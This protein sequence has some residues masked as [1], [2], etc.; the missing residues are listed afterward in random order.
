MENNLSVEYIRWFYKPLK[1]KNITPTVEPFSGYDTVRI[2]TKYQE[3]CNGLNL[4]DCKLEVREGLYEIDFSTR[5]CTPIYW[6][7][8]RIPKV[9]RSIF[10][11][12]A[13]VQRGLWFRTDNW[14]PID[15]AESKALEDVYINEILKLPNLLV[16]K[17]EKN[18]D[19]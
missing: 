19:S 8:D 11:R 12:S 9:S 18:D 17:N 2:E 10:W 1:C 4:G 14:Q 3:F 7:C 15:E 5:L 16:P 6:N 13:I